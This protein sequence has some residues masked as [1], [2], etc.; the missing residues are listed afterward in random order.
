MTASKT[1]HRLLFQAILE[2]RN[3]SYGTGD[4]AVYHLADLF[5]HVVLQLE[6]VA[7]GKTDITYDDV[8]TFIK[9]RAREK[10]CEKW[11]DDRISELA[12]RSGEKSPVS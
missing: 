7:E 3:Q 1:V 11:V 2:I 4:K 6:A 12:I 9:E 8:L 5:H 10:G